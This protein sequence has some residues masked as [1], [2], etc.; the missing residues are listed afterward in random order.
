MDLPTLLG[1][2]VRQLRATRGR[3]QSDMAK[4]S[5]LPRAT[6]AN[7][8]S[9]AGNPT[10][11]VLHRVATALQVTI[12]ELISPPRAAAQ[13]YP[14][15]TLRE[16]V[17]G[18][19]TVRKLLPGDLPGTS[20]DRMELPPGSRLTGVPHTPGTREVLGCET[21]RLQLVVSGESF[22]LEPGDV[23]S[24]RGDQRHSYANPIPVHPEQGRRGTAIA[25]SVVILAP[26]T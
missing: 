17:A 8:E 14:R 13:H 20:V 11:A 2:N 4:L 18:G 23:V 22:T 3:T 19:V 12:E 16:R 9:G 25:Y 15:A 7:L 6:W 1:D 24:F 26:L 21:G 10:L 5:G